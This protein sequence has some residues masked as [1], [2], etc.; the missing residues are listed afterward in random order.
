MVVVVIG[1][2]A[3]VEVVVLLVVIGKTPGVDVVVLLV[4]VVVVVGKTPG[5]LVVVVVTASSTLDVTGRELDPK[6]G[7]EGRRL[8][9]KSLEVAELVVV[10]VVVMIGKAMLDV[11]SIKLLV[12]LLVLLSGTTL[13]ATLTVPASRPPPLATL[14]LR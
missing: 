10:V 1:R 4:V 11:K 14:G 2:T 5:V 13:T 3:G 7:K 8:D 9:T 6:S 12:V